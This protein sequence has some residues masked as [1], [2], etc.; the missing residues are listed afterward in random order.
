[1]WAWRRQTGVDGCPVSQCGLLRLLG[2]A[3]P[4]YF[5]TNSLASEEPITL[6]GVQLLNVTGDMTSEPYLVPVT[7]QGAGTYST[8]SPQRVRDWQWQ[9]ATPAVG[10]ALDGSSP[11]MDLVLRISTPSRGRSAAIRVDY[12]RGG[13]FYYTVIPNS[14]EVVSQGRC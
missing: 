12:E 5:G 8:F 2:P 7:A 11:P 9:D 3:R 10:S 6:T 4:A 14:I 13:N 1:M